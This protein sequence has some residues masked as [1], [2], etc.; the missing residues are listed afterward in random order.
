MTPSDRFGKVLQYFSGAVALGMLFSTIGYPFFISWDVQQGWFLQNPSSLEGNLLV[1]ASILIGVAVIQAQNLNR[2]KDILRAM[3]TRKSGG[4]SGALD[5]TRFVSLMEK[6]SEDPE[7]SKDLKSIL[8]EALTVIE[9]FRH[10]TAKVSEDL[11]KT[12][13][14]YEFLLRGFWLLSLAI[15]VVILTLAFA[16]LVGSPL[17]SLAAFM[18]STGWWTTIWLIIIGWGCLATVAWRSYMFDQ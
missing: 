10:D 9:E 15:I 12:M 4:L 8:R 2:M 13:E 7:S 6:L 5:S 16:V 14:V 18:L 3:R 1:F 11:A 17:S